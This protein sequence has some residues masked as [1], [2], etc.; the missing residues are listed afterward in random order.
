MRQL[1]LFS[2]ITLSLL[3]LSCEKQGKSC[4]E[5]QAEIDS[6]LNYIEITK[7][8]ANNDIITAGQA[9]MRINEALE[10]IAELQKELEDCD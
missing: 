4:N 6:Q 1:I 10:K 7:A 3:L 8:S 9:T 2:I 5:I